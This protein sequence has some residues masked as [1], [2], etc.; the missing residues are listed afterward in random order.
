MPPGMAPED[1][2][3]EVSIATDYAISLGRGRYCAR[4]PVTRAQMAAMLEFLNAQNAPYRS[5]REE[6]R[7]SLFQDNCVHLAHNALA[8][9]GVWDEWPTNRAMLFALF[10]FPVPKNEFVNIVRRTNDP[11]LLDPVAIYRDPAARQSVLR[12]GQLPVR[13]GAIVQSWPP[14]QP[15]EVYETELKLVF[16]DEPHFGPYRGWLNAIL[17]DPRYFDLER[18]LRYFAARYRQLQASQQPLAWWLAQ[19]EF[20]GASSAAFITAFHARFY[21][22]LDREIEAIDA[23][24][25]RLQRVRAIDGA[26]SGGLTSVR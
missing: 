2:K 23:H 1:Y 20:R 25:A 11:D 4:V 6:F 16:Y 14:R 19:D 3:Y 10:D 5:G 15:N 12:F 13:P 21:I 8:A 18:N 9:A 24:L 26:A 17:A 7:W 22:A